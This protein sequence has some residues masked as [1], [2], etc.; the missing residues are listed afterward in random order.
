MKAVWKYP[1]ES[2]SFNVLTMPRGAKVLSCALQHGKLC[3]WALVEPSAPHEVREFGIFATGEPIHD[4][5]ARQL[6]FVATFQVDGGD[7]IF[8]VFE[9][10]REA[11]TT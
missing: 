7:F 4:A 5:E 2:Q 8:H 11:N 3:L 10:V 1:L 9:Y 6:K